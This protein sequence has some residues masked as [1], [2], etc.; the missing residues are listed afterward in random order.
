MWSSA[1]GQTL[2]ALSQG[3]YSGDPEGSPALPNTGSLR[4]V[5]ADGSLS[6]IASG[7]DRPTS[8]E[9]IGNTAYIITL[10]GEI[11][12]IS[13]IDAPPFGQAN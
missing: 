2:F 10:T 6:I 9:I 12:T 5:N 11:W 4:K 1:R 8:M 3:D 13:N 7:L